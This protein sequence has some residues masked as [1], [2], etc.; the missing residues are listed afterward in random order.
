MMKIKMLIFGM[1]GFCL[2]AGAQDT[3]WFLITSDDSVVAVSNVDYLEENTGSPTFNIVLKDGTSI[4]DVATVSVSD[5]S[6]TGIEEI[7]SNDT[8]ALA[9][10]FDKRW[11]EI[12]NIQVPCEIEIYSLNGMK[13]SSSSA[14]EGS[15][16]VDISMLSPGPY[17]LKAGNRT[18][19]FMK[20]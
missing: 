18:I 8:E 10:N 19:K 16:M 20:P 5:T 9:I 14:G 6:S 17:L 7:L 15:C 3:G 2:P 13:V 1:L 12:S 4:V 11:I